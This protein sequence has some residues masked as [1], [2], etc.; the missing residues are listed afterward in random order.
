LSLI[1]ETYLPGPRCLQRF[2]SYA[3]LW[4]EDATPVVCLTPVG[5]HDSS[6]MHDCH[7]VCD[8]SCMP[9]SDRRTRLR[10]YAQL[11]LEDVTPVVCPTPIRRHNLGHMCDSDCMPNSGHMLDS[12]HMPNS[13]RKTLLRSY[14]RLWSE[15]ATLV[16]FATSIVCPTLVR[17]H[18]SSRLPHSD[19]KTWFW[20]EG[21]TPVAHHDPGRT[22]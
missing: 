12:G 10:S 14:A 5:R 16:V 19:R 21:M 22:S 18:G 8:S 20:L 17:R 7:H 6:C 13:S 3:R 1:T 4:L 11:W 15:G 2:R 9:D